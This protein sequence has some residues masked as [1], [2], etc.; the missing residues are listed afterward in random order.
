MKSANDDASVNAKSDLLAQITQERARL[1]AVLQQMPGGVVIVDAQSGRV[2]MMNVE[3]ERLARPPANSSASLAIPADA[4]VEHGTRLLHPDDWPLTRALRT[5]QITTNQEM[6][7]L[8]DDGSL[9][10]VLVSAAP[11][12]NGDRM[13]AA[14]AT[15]NDITGQRETAARLDETQAK[16]LALFNS[17]VIGLAW[18]ESEMIS[19]AN[20][21]LLRTL[22]CTRDDLPLDWNRMTPPDQRWINDRALREGLNTGRFAPFERDFIRKDGS[23]VPVVIGGYMLGADP[24]QY[25]ACV[26]AV[27]RSA[28]RSTQS[29]ATCNC[30]RWVLEASAPMRS[31]CISSACARAAAICF[32]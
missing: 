17:N 18:G 2:L 20:D 27:T 21:E 10:T 32:I 12:R 23:F 4:L 24:F 1:E 7:Y 9:G 31:G 11:I 6:Q 13:E 19:E 29:S 16:L 15:F 30:W 22:G 5:G 26:L 3:A 8:R 28:H 25:V 14:V